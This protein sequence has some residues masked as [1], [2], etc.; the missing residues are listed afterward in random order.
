MPLATLELPRLTIR[1]RGPMHIGTGFARGLVNR[2]V[3]RGRDGLVYV[4]GSAIKGKVRS[5]CEALARLHGVSDCRAPHPQRMAK[6]RENC[7]VCRIFGAPGQ[8]SNLHWQL[9][10]L[11]QDWVEA[12]HPTL[13]TRAVP[14]QTMTRTQVQLSRKRGLATEARLFTSEFAAEGLTFEAAP[15]LTGRVWLTPMTVADAEDVYYELVLLFASLKLVGSLGGGTSRGAGACEIA[16]PESVL[17]NG[18]TVLVESQ[19][20]NI[21]GLSLYKDEAEVQP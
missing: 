10:R 6:D 15:G 18:R 3:V 14:G 20:A 8:G 9:A 2:T 13:G 11:T 17:V 1:V 21:D 12:L 4:P 19:L 16:L 7:V 5:A